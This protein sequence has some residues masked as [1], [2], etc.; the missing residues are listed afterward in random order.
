MNAKFLA[1]LDELERFQLPPRRRVNDGEEVGGRVRA[2][3]K[4]S[5][6]ASAS[7]VP[8]I[9]VATAPAPVPAPRRTAPAPAPTIRKKLVNATK[10]PKPEIVAQPKKVPLR[11]GRAAPS[12]TRDRAHREAHRIETLALV[13]EARAQGCILL[14]EICEHLNQKNHKPPRHDRWSVSILAN[15]FPTEADKKRRLG[16]LATLFEE[17]RHLG[18]IDYQELAD[19]LNTRSIR[20]ILG[21]QWT[22]HSVGRVKRE[23]MNRSPE[24]AVENNY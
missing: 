8:P 22:R 13:E 6:N 9:Q 21:R 1:L 24:N 17:A 23:M 10:P 5:A 4:M 14:K 18:V 3:I 7:F 11:Q 2:T 20:T 15:M 19:F 12:V 16:N